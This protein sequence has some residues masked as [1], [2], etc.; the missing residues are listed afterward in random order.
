MMSAGTASSARAGVFAAFIIVQFRQREREAARR[1][2]SQKLEAMGQLASGVAHDFGNLL[3]IVVS[4]LRRVPD[5]TNDPKVR[6]AAEQALGAAS[7]GLTLTRQ[8][9]NFAR[10]EPIRVE[11]VDLEALLDD[12][13]PLLAQSLGPG[14]TLKIAVEPE[15][16]FVRASG[17][18]LDLAL[19]NMAV[20]ARDAMPG[21]GELEVRAAADPSQVGWVKVQVR[22]T[23]HG[24][25]G[26]V[27]DRLMEP[28]FTTKPEGK[29]TGLGAMQILAA[30]RPSGGAVDVHSEV[31]VGTTFTLRLPA[32]SEN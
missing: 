4:A 26:E 6:L 17:A 31:G 24:M 11:R 28:F 21:G 20:N 27:L 7:R 15:A 10:T 14:I 29:G 18:L 9:L 2:Q 32:W 25:T 3:A 5:D 19:L 23:G 30:V 22:D 13:R 16:R 1:L 8:L 12:L